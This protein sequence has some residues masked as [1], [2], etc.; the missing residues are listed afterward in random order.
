MKN[1]SR[2]FLTRT[3]PH[4]TDSNTLERLPVH[5]VSCA[6]CF[7]RPLRPSLTHTYSS[8]FECSCRGSARRCEDEW[9]VVVVQNLASSTTEALQVLRNN[10]HCRLIKRFKANPFSESRCPKVQSV[11]AILTLQHATPTIHSSMHS[12]QPAELG[13]LGSA[14]QLGQASADCSAR[15]PHITN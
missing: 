12:L 7:S 9:H 11:V 5:K 13:E 2:C 6:R 8:L 1:R 14:A 15:H 10:K 4:T 3:V